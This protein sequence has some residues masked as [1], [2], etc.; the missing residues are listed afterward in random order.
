MRTRKQS[1]PANVNDVGR[2]ALFA[3]ECSSQ[4]V[5]RILS[6]CRSRMGDHLSTATGYP[7]PLAANPRVIA[8]RAVSSPPIWPC[9]GWGLPGQPV[10]RLPVSSYLTIS[11]LPRERG[12]MFLLRY[13]A[14]HPVWVLPSALPCGVRTFLDP[15]PLLTSRRDHPAGLS[16]ATVTQSGI[17]VN[18]PGDAWQQKRLTLRTDRV[19]SR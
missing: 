9:S 18:E 17:A 3:R 8:R 4:P 5:S 2:C 13:P 15:P 12:G 1:T 11:P 6:P 14:G 16:T 10:T 7:S 19:Y